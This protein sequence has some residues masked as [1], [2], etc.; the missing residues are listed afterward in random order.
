MLNYS[1]ALSLVKYEKKE[2]IEFQGDNN[3]VLVK[4]FY[5]ILLL[6]G[7]ILCFL[8]GNSEVGNITRGFLFFLIILPLLA[9]ST[10]KLFDGVDI[11]LYKKRIRFD[12]KGITYNHKKSRLTEKH[13]GKESVEIIRGIRVGNNNADLF[14]RFYLENIKKPTLEFT[15]HVEN[16]LPK[17]IF[18]EELN[19]IFKFK[20][21]KQFKIDRNRTYFEFSN[22]EGFT[23]ISK[24]DFLKKEINKT[25]EIT[26][27]ISSFRYLK[28][29]FEKGSL[30]YKNNDFLINTIKLV[31]IKR[32]DFTIKIEE[33][34][35]EMKANIIIKTKEGKS[36]EILTNK[37]N[38]STKYTDVMEYEK[39]IQ[40]QNL[41][42]QLNNV[43][44]DY[45]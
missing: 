8:I 45:T 40:L 10:N 33:K 6:I 27:A 35:L 26:P 32:F 23:M 30:T 1:K 2:I 5:S 13:V 9:M 19:E 37:I 22:K 20:Y 31:E 25:L 18:L 12:E 3:Y 15:F 11:S 21:V 29:D 39:S 17:K 34:P 43:L 44:K 36:F 16:R 38:L 14:F 28:I 41:I 24:E 4:F 7:L 42:L